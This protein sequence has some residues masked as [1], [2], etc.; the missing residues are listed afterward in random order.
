MYTLYMYNA[1]HNETY[2]PETLFVSG[3][4]GKFILQRILFASNIVS[5]CIVLNGYFY[6]FH[7]FV[8]KILWRLFNGT[9]I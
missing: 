5:Y 3:L 2:N 9:S 7:C 1:Q 8:I 6:L 4:L